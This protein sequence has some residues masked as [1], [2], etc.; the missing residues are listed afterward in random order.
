MCKIKCK[1]RPVVDFTDVIH[2]SRLQRTG[3]FYLIGYPLIFK[4][5]MNFDL[6]RSSI[7]HTRII[8]KYFDHKVIL[9]NIALVCYYT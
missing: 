9:L 3:R 5:D 6:T 1:D 8:S 4:M 2:I 7:F